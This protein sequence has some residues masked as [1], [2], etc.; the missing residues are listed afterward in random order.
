MVGLQA[1][2]NE[3]AFAWRKFFKDLK[4]RGLDGSAITREIMDGLT[5]PEGVFKEEFPKVRIQR[6]QVHVA[7][8][9][10]VKVPHKLKGT[11]ADDLK[12]IFYASS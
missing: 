2:D 8:N 12:S 1:G 10:L 6:C 4:R 7:R 3:S 9:V 5:G 11:V